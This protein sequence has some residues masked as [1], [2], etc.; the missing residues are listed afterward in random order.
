MA[1]RIFAETPDA[2]RASAGCGTLNST[3]LWNAGVS[4]KSRRPTP[5]PPLA[6]KATCVESHKNNADMRT[7]VFHAVRLLQ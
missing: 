2:R 3:A 5:P 6:A 7:Q 4:A 1:M